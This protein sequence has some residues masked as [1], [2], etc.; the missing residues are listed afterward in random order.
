MA[1]PDRLTHLTT[2]ERREKGRA[3]RK[4]TPRTANAVWEP[5]ANRPDPVQLLSEQDESRV[6]DLVPIRHGRMLVSP[7]TF[8]RGAARIMASDLSTTPVSGLTTQLCGDAHLSNFGVFGS[9]ERELLFDINDFDETLPGPWEWDVKRMAASFAIAGRHREFDDR[10]IHDAVQTSAESYRHAMEGFAA[11][12]TLDVWYSHLSSQDILKAI[13]NSGASKKRVEKLFNKAR[14]RD[15][16]Q[17]LDKLTEVVDGKRQIVDQPPTVARLETLNPGVEPADIAEI[18]HLGLE[19]YR[20][21]LLD[22]RRH[23]LEKYRFVDAARK[24]VG[25]GSV[26]TRA[27]ILLL[28]ARD[29][30]IDPLFLQIKQASRSVLEEHLP[31]SRY[32]NHGRRV[33]EG[34][35]L[36]QAAS[37]IFLGWVRG[38]LPVKADYYWRQLRDMKGSVDMEN[39]R[40]EGLVFYAGLCGWTLAR[41]HARA[42]DPIAMSAYLGAGPVFERSIVEFSDAY[43]DQNEKDYAAY[44]AAA[45][46]G[47]IEVIEGV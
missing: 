28:E 21:T 23:L 45:K 25:V 32:Q 8:Y 24:V 2:D 43:A 40:P 42:G 37:D 16:L 46:A 12:T 31:K 9:P 35:R 29:D 17:A 47:T 7:F 3:A 10:V 27:Y 15:G 1:T 34:Q 41:A 11:M 39:I 19:A 14:M 30:R 18:I 26:G 33:V 36:Q 38:E 13:P 20:T 5:A 6:P 44:A 4:K 22:D